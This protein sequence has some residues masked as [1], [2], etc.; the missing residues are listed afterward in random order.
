MPEIA[1]NR[2][3]LAQYKIR[4]SFMIIETAA[5]TLA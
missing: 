2:I 3:H 5:A 1:E 4:R